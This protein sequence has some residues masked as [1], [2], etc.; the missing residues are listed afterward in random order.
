MTTA[1]GSRARRT[2]T[3]DMTLEAFLKTRTNTVLREVV[4]LGAL[5][6]VLTSANSHFTGAD[7]TY[8]RTAFYVGAL[9]A[10]PVQLVLHEAAHA[11]TA[12]AF[13]RRVLRIVL[14]AGP[15]MLRVRIRSCEVQIRPL[16]WSGC[17]WYAPVLPR[18]RRGVVSAAGP[19]VNAL[20]ALIAAL[21][22]PVSPLMLG[23][24]WINT[25]ELITNLWP[26]RVRIG[27]SVVNTDGAAVLEAIAG[28]DARADRQNG[29]LLR[30][31]VEEAL[32]RSGRPQASAF[33]L[34]TAL[35]REPSG[36][37]G[38]I[39]HRAGLTVERARSIASAGGGDAGAVGI[40][41][42]GTL[43]SVALLRALLGRPDIAAAL[44]PALTAQPSL[45]DDYELARPVAPRST[46]PVCDALLADLPLE[47]LSAEAV[48]ALD[49]ATHL[50]TQGDS[51]SSLCLFA[52]LVRDAT[53]V[54]ARA[55]REMNCAVPVTATPHDKTGITA[56]LVNAI[57]LGSTSPLFA[58]NERITTAALLVGVWLNNEDTIAT[59]LEA[60]GVPFLRLLE[61]L[62]R[63]AAMTPGE[64]SCQDRPERSLR[65]L[66]DLRAHAQLRLHRSVEAMHGFTALAS[67]APD[68]RSLALALNNAAWAALMSDREALR[69]EALT[70]SARA[71]MLLPHHSAVRGTHAFALIENGQARDGVALIAPLV[72]KA[73]PEYM[74]TQEC[75]L[76]IGLARLAMIEDARRYV[77]D[78][79]SLDP[80][81]RLLPRA[82]AAMT[83]LSAAVSP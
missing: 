3:A 41:I 55:L 76:A 52:A 31:A 62:G 54:A 63:H 75:I 36:R 77:D 32:A 10:I 2:L 35:L 24:L 81:E 69:P 79:A 51:G 30:V 50:R 46:L 19:A 80:A 1:A 70:L 23:A 71:I 48:L 17:T 53:S 34:V 49:R 42:E 83:G 6:F 28:R 61:A 56:D 5:F 59:R 74:A 57:V 18:G 20:L 64:R 11:I 67:S 25:A 37:G 29:A 60:R 73:A 8:D 26:A 44:Q 15:T 7:R 47:R 21:L 38:A 40:P 4:T 58:A 12:L 45:T 22:L 43:N 72:A 13:R 33:D 68:E 82:A 39:L 78:A 27:G 14:G 16:L 66:A 9:L 65:W